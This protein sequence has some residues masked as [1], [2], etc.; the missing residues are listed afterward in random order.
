M[1]PPVQFKD[2]NVWHIGKPDLVVKSEA[3]TIPATG[4]DWWGDYIVDTGADRRPIA[5][6]AVETKP[7]IGDKQVVAPCGRRT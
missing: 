2:D 6:S 7:G 4:S 5:A 3:H 1:P